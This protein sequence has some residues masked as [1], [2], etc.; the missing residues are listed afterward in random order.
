MENMERLPLYHIYLQAMG[1]QKREG[2]R[3]EA[4]WTVL[5]WLAKINITGCNG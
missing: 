1:N 4:E 3:A 2:A 5:S